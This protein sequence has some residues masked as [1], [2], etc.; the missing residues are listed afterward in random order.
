MDESK[1]K[2]IRNL[3]LQFLITAVNCLITLF[4][5]S[6]EEVASLVFDSLIC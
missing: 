4:N 5:P 3:L 1:K 6:T 2:S